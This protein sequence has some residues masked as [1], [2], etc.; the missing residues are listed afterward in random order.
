[1]Q[2]LQ[3]I[4]TY[5]VEEEVRMIAQDKKWKEYQEKEKS[6]IKVSAEVQQRAAADVMPSFS[7][8]DIKP[9]ER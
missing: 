8:F 5:L 3:N 4:E 1:M 6:R 7:D 9:D 2:V